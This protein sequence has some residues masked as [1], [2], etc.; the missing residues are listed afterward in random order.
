MKILI[1]KAIGNWQAMSHMASWRRATIW[2]RPTMAGTV[3]FALM[4]CAHSRFIEHPIT[5]LF[6]VPPEQKPVSMS[7]M[8]QHCQ[9]LAKQR[10]ADVAS[11]GEDDTIQSEVSRRTYADCIAWETR[12][13]VSQ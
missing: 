3:F 11:Q 4:G 7:P 9:E 1:M 6:T 12:H 5:A 13:S 10:A 2:V 8:E